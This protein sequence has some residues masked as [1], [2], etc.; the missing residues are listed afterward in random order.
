MEGGLELIDVTDRA[1]RSIHLRCDERRRSNYHSC[2]SDSS[3]GQADAQHLPPADGV[4]CSDYLLHLTISLHY[5]DLLKSVLA[6]APRS[7]CSAS[8]C[9]PPRRRTP[10]PRQPQRSEER[11]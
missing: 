5:F 4:S 9:R 8:A 1:A 3:S 2:Q 10:A 6:C 7:R 11:R